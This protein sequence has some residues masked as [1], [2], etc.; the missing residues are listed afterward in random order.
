ML[1]DNKKIAKDVIDLALGYGTEQV[2][3]SLAKSISFQVDVR[4]NKIESL[5][6]SGS[7][8]IHI[9]ISKNNRRSTVSSND[10]REETLAPLIRSTLEALPYM[11]EDK[12]YT[13]PDP[14]LQGRAPGDLEFLDPDYSKLSSG[15][16]VKISLNLEALSLNTDQRLKTDQSFY[17]DS[18]SYVVHAD[19]NGFLEG[20]TKTLYSM[21]ISM[22]ADDI[23]PKSNEREST[24]V[25]RKQTDGWYSAA[26]FHKNLTSPEDIVE[27]ARR[28]TLRKLGA[29]KPPSQEVP[30]VFSSEMAQSFLGKIASALMG[31]NLFRKQSFLLNK[32]DE[33]IA[34]A[35]INLIDNPLL[36]GKLGSRHFDSEGVQ[37]KPLVL[38]ENG[39]LKN[40]MLSTYSANKLGMASN[41]HSG[42]ISNLILKL[43]DYP[44]EELIASVKN[45]LYL[46]S[47]TGQGANIVTGDFSRGGQGIWIREGKLAEPVSEFTIAGTFAE[48]LNNLKMIGNEIDERSS[49]LTP[50]FK[51]DKM[52]VS[53]T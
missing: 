7:S 6:E 37:A 23:E 18:K 10:F 34:N 28:R 12:F 17:S 46:T 33:S 15:E 31:E 52:M 38:I 2:S 49:I 29:V 51:I 32:L 40:Y 41:G 53:G 35:K 5:Q 1:E 26:R 9:T 16:K 14:A 21:G 27:K 20:E 45:G 22:I 42:G 3:V 24:N 48:M 50:A 8:G 47:M 4:E 39:V 30:V 44:E 36:P 11:G 19:S 13:L 43:G 25:G